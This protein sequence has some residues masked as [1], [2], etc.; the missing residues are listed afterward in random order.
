MNDFI[1][2]FAVFFAAFAGVAGYRQV[3]ERIGAIDIPNERSSHRRPVPRGGGIVIAAVCLI[4]FWI[5]AWNFTH[6]R[7]FWHIWNFGLVISAIGFYDDLRPLGIGLRL[8]MQF[9]V[10]ALFLSALFYGAAPVFSP[11]IFYPL[12]I[13]WM[14]AVINAFNF[15]DGIDGMIALAAFTGG[16]FWRFFAISS[17]LPMVA[18]ASTITSAAALAFFLHNR[19]PARIFLGDS[20]SMFF[21]FVF[22]AMPF[23]ALQESTGEIS[24]QPFFAGAIF[25]WPLLADAFLT[26]LRRALKVKRFWEPNRDHFYQRLVDSGLLVQGRSHRFVS[27]LYAA[28]AAVA[29]AIF[30]FFEAQSGNLPVLTVLFVTVSIIAGM[31]LAMK[32]GKGSLTVKDV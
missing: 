7:H 19:Q 9:L 15:L 17:D 18:T 27:A 16:V 4:F 5:F 28:A 21:G 32:I 10:S 24:P 8:V 11:V 6:F 22:A 23:V 12:A 20:G 3:A 26:R 13:V 29:S 2:A 25:I 14:I 1:A 31:F 30:L